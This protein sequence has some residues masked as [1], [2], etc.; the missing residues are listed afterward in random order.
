[1]KSRRAFSFFLFFTILTGLVFPAGATE[2]PFSKVLLHVPISLP[3][4]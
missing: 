4:G 2:T 1:M 3:L